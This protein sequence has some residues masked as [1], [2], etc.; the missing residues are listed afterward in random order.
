MYKVYFFTG[1]SL[2]ICYFHT[3]FTATWTA[4]TSATRARFGLSPLFSHFSSKVQG[5]RTVQPSGLTVADKKIIKMKNNILQTIVLLL[6]G[7]AI[8]FVGFIILL[9]GIGESTP[10]YDEMLINN[11]GIFSGVV[12]FLDRIVR[13]AVGA[14]IMYVGYKIYP[15][16]DEEG[17][18]AVENEIDEQDGQIIVNTIKK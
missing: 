10:E 16:K 17:E 12:M 8:L 9:S 13:L 14:A 3:I 2:R 15:F 6:V 1:S 5:F 11:F 7:F 18:Q 4:A